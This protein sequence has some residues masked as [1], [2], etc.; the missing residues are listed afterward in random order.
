MICP[1]MKKNTLQNIIDA[2]T[3]LAPVV[4]VPEEIRIPAL[5]AVDRMMATPRG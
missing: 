3:N 2:L 5:K 4:K 1:N